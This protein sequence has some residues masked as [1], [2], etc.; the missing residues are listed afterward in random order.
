MGKKKLKK[1]I[2]FWKGQER[3]IGKKAVDEEI[4]RSKR[5]YNKH[6]GRNKHG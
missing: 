3:L 4:K 2:K 5:R 6:R 1:D